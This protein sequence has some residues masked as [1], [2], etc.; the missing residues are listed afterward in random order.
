MPVGQS[1][2]RSIV[3]VLSRR[4]GAQY[5]GKEHDEEQD[6]QCDAEDNLQ[7]PEGFMEGKG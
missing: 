5:H 1:F 3:R 4:G 7:A 2:A 6:G